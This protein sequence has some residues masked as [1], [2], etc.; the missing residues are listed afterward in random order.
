M[1]NHINHDM[2]DGVVNQSGNMYSYH[3]DDAKNAVEYP[4]ETNA[5]RRS[6]GDGNPKTLGV[7]IAKSSEQRIPPP[8][9]FNNHVPQQQPQM[10]IFQSG[11]QYVDHLKYKEPKP[12]YFM[13][14]GGMI[15]YQ[16]IIIVL[17]GVFYK[18]DES[19][20]PKNTISGINHASDEL[21]NLH[22]FFKDVHLMVFVGF[23]MLFTLLKH[24]NWSSVAI[25]LIVAVMTIEFGFFSHFLWSYTFNKNKL[26]F[27][28][29][30][31]ILIEFNAITVLISLGTLIGK[32]PISQY[33]IIS[34]LESIGASLNFHLCRDELKAKDIGGSMYV[35]LYGGVSAITISFLLFHKSEEK[36]KIL[37]SP[38]KSTNY[39]STILSFIGTI[40]IWILFPSFNTSLIV[41]KNNET[42]FVQRYRGIV[43]T[44]LSMCG[45]VIGCFSFSPIFND[46]KMKIEQILNASYAGGVI[47]GGC[48]NVCGHAWASLLIGLLGGSISTISMQFLKNLLDKGYLEDIIGVLHVFVIPGFLGGILSCI[49]I[50]DLKN[51]KSYDKESAFNDFNF[52]K[53]DKSDNLGHPAGIQIAALA[54]TLGISFLWSMVIG[55][56]I[57]TCVCKKNEKYYV[58]S[59]YFI[60]GDEMFPEYETKYA[61]ALPVQGQ[62]LSSS[63]NKINAST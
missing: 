40:F 14:Y 5:I 12:Q 28:F 19:N 36:R 60:E 32:L 25:N 6:I 34:I 30:N 51:I 10:M 33:L 31:L 46:G 7:D 8:A 18:Y 17:I 29:E 24:H 26:E 61:F 27:N 59:E 43:N 63:G 39:T 57:K 3:E 20:L 4:Q 49:F 38:H 1:E 22:T 13:I 41:K 54:I 50:A 9:F 44:Y 42:V 16:I 15:I 2:N 35:F 23:G 56:T 11:P 21:K 62:N 55:F 52:Y 53:K 48:C 45:S 58:D 47:I 37:E